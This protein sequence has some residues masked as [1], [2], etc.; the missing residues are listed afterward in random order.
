MGLVLGLFLTAA[1][2]G[3]G[4]GPAA[5]DWPQV[6]GT[7]QQ[8]QGGEAGLDTVS[9]LLSDLPAGLRA[10]VAR[11]H[12]ALLMGEEPTRVACTI[13]PE[14]A[15]GGAWAFA[16]AI[17]RGPAL[18]QA[19]CL[20]LAQTPDSLLEPLFERGYREF[21]AHS[22]AARADP[23]LALAESLHARALAVWSAQN[24]AIARTRS[25]AYTGAASV[26]QERLKGPLSNPDRALLASRLSI[27]HLGEGGLLSARRALGRGLLRRG[28]DSAIVLGLLALEG[29]G[30]DRSR[31]LY[32][33]VLSRDPEQPWAQRGWGLSMVPR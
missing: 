19:L 16:L 33:S 11:H 7:L 8:A 3:T 29:G 20:G 4:R 5:S 18:D 15:P 14:L 22:E 12:H 23:A 1:L 6:W 24:L 31:R 21:L 30:T 17:D 26:L 13:L 9:E 2:C 10:Q 32:R 25:G 27:V 28:S